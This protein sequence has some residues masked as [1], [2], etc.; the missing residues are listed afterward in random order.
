M[1]IQTFTKEERLCSKKL[2]DFL[3]ANSQTFY[4]NPF[5]IKWVYEDFETELPAQ[6][7]VVVPKRYFKKAHD[8]NKIKRQIREAYRKNK[9]ILY[10]PLIINRKKIA[11]AI[12]YNE[13]EI[14]S[15][16]FI[17]EKIILTLQRLKQKL[18]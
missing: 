12:I 4:V 14:F 8:R 3:F 18:E 9:K 17:E 1:Q 6:S 10:D 15:S 5:K 16:N 13:K 2:I 11:I 7:L